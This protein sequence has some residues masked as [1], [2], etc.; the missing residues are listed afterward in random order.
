MVKGGLT[1]TAN[2]SQQQWDA[3]NSWALLHWFA[4]TGLQH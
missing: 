2:R 3:P 4:V 1:T